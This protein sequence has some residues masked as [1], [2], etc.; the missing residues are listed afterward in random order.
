MIKILCE[1]RNK[2]LKIGKIVQKSEIFRL[3][4]LSSTNRIPIKD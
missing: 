4:N 2:A 1:F 3:L